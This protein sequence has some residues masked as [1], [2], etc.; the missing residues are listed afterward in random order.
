M[1]RYQFKKSW[2]LYILGASAV[3]ACLFLLPPHVST[4]FPITSSPSIPSGHQILVQRFSELSL[5]RK[6]ENTFSKHCGSECVV[7]TGGCSLCTSPSTVGANISK[8]YGLPTVI[9]IIGENRDSRILLE[10]NALK[11][12][13]VV[14][15]PK[16]KMYLLQP[17]WP[18]RVHK[19]R[20]GRFIQSQM[21]FNEELR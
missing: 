5:G 10:G 18:Y 3:L 9:L 2:I 21:A 12:P 20:Q 11:V 7:A 14:E 6:I 19:I 4:I 17:D 13:L 16:E 15:I 8:V 1:A